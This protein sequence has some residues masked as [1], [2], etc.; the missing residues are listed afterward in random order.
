MKP[1]DPNRY[2]F[3]KLADPTHTLPM[4]R[5]GRLF[6]ANP[7]HPGFERVDIHDQFYAMLFAGGSI[8]RADPPA[9]TPAAPTDHVDPAAAE[10]ARAAG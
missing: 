7:E 4:P 1:L 10:A 2:V 6:G 9:H 5:K 8:V 3:A